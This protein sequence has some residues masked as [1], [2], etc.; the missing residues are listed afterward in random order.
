VTESELPTEATE[1]DVL[2]QHTDAQPEQEAPPVGDDEP[3]WEA[4][5]ADVAEQEQAV[6]EDDEYA[7]EE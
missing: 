6:G 1:A 4:N 3:D 7:T 5:P 2:E